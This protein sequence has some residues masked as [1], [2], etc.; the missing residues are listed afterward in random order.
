MKTI[1]N[2]NG[3]LVQRI[4]GLDLPHLADHDRVNARIIG[5]EERQDAHSTPDDVLRRIEMYEPGQFAAIFC[6][7]SCW[8][9]H[10][11]PY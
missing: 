2:A 3:T 8:I 5:V 9:T 6:S 11:Y 1:D 10:E 4:H 7:S